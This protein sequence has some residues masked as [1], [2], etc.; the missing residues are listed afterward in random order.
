MEITAI[1]SEQQASYVM[2]YSAL[3]SENIP[4]SFISGVPFY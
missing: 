4:V 2:K 3:F 1:E